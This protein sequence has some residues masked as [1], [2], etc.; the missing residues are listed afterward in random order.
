MRSGGMPTVKL[1]DPQ[2]AELVAY[3]GGLQLSPSG[4]PQGPPDSEARLAAPQP[5]FQTDRSIQAA[6]TQLA[7]TSLSPEALRG[8]ALFQSN[9]CGTCHGAGGV[10]GTVAA[11]GLA[12][13]AS[14]LPPATLESLLRHY[15]ARMREGGMPSIS[16]SA[17]EIQAIVAYIRAL[18][19][20]PGRQSTAISRLESQAQ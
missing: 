12:G 20:I 8:Q 15:S 3:L 9:A 18:N 17:K 4:P 10:N 1:D 2:L 16:F 14:L 13:T 7:N 6:L 5:A 11:P 19:P